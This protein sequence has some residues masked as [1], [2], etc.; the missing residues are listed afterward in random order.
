M[1]IR[2]PNKTYYFQYIYH[3]YDLKNKIRTLNSE[4]LLYV[5]SIVIA[6]TVSATY[7]MKI[8]QMWKE[9]EKIYFKW[10][11]S[12]VAICHVKTDWV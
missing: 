9:K 12:P 5:G 10:E 4:Q 11:S 8:T 2:H 1:L 7:A 6:E 3:F